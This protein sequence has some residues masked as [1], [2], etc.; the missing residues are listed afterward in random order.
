MQIFYLALSLVFAS[1]F[2]FLGN[3][4]SKFLRLDLI[5]NKIS[6]PS[7]QYTLIGLTLFIFI[8]YPI[9]FFGFFKVVSFSTVS[10]VII[11]FGLINLSKNFKNIINLSKDSF[12]KINKVNFNS[13]LIILLIILY[14]LLSI[15][16]ITSG[17]S[18]S[19]NMGSA[20]Y[21]MQ[22]GQFSTDLFYT[23]APLVGAGEFLNAFAL[24]INAYQFT[25]L[26]N[27]IGVIS[28]IGIIKKFCANNFVSNDCQNF[29]LLCVLSCPI[30]T[31]FISS[32]KS[33]L[34][35]TSL[36]FFSYAL[37]IY[38]LNFSVK[39]NFLIKAS[40][41]LIVLPIVAVQTKLTFSLSFFLIITTFFFV[42]K[43]EIKIKNFILM[44]TL[45]CVVG[46]LPQILWKQNVYDY[47]FY[48]FIINPI[49]MNIPGFD[50]AYSDLRSYSSEK[51]PYLLLLPLE[52]QDLTQ[53]IGIGMLSIFF[54]FKNS[55]KNKKI[56]I[57]IILSFFFVYSLFGP[58]A[59]RFYVEIYF[60]IILI[61]TFVIKDIYKNLSFRI[62][63][64]GVLVQSIFV[65]SIVLFGVINLLPG[66]LSDNLH[67]KVLSK[68]ASGYNLYSWANSV[69]PND[70][71]TLINHRSFYFAKK[72]MIY[73]GMAGFLDN[74]TINYHL[75]NMKEKKVNYILFHGYQDTF[76]YGEFNFKDCTQGLFK[77]KINVAFYETRNPFNT[78][79]YY[80]AYIY[81]L[82]ATKLDNCVK[83][84]KY[85]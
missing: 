23:E 43:K 46:L 42:F 70:S 53:F 8:F 72:E 27:F 81:K 9:F 85:N 62:L 6:N 20:K 25:S 36:I 80:N 4:A 84:E 67:K 11:L 24:S 7:Y 48:N 45:L 16:P 75:K 34:F 12:N 54:L 39:K 58:K 2:Y 60:L 40:Y 83:Y 29:L 30:L 66:T 18:V 32:S 47:P 82:D 55:F 17:D 59:A 78:G 51:F 13:F 15:S 74:S 56:I 22:Y 68:Y 64:Y 26:I 76:N 61:F 49:P 21:I 1:G 3:S 35:S 69:L 14:F 28:I 63:N 33:Q 73:F 41:F 38:C 71:V 5:I 77:K 19:Y 50:E 79:N 52:L 44:F 57:T 31:F 65:L 37:L 10:Y